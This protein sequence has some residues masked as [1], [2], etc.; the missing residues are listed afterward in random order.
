[1]GIFSI[2]SESVKDLPVIETMASRCLRRRLN[3]N[4]CTLCID[5]C[6][7]QALSI[8]ENGVQVVASDRCSSCGRCTAVCP[9]EVF[10]FPGIDLHRTLQERSNLENMTISCSRN[11]AV[12][13]NELCLPCIGALSMEALLHLGL[14]GSGDVHFDVT[15]CQKCDNYH[16]VEKV[17]ASMERLHTVLGHCLSANLTAIDDRAKLMEIQHRDRRSFLRNMGDNVVSFVKNHYGPSSWEKKSHQSKRRR[18]P[19]KTKLLHNIFTSDRQSCGE[20]LLAMCL[21]SIAVTDSCTLCPRCTGMCPTGALKVGRQEGAKKL[22][23]DAFR[24]NACGLCETFCKER[25]I[26]V[27]SAPLFDS[28]ENAVLRS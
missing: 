17:L 25:A 18:I 13:P 7:A 8:D 16:A 24:C 14:R 19:G 9:G 26:T 23:I 11:T 4:D 22:S 5:S 12:Y 21:P 15:G 28:T 27:T 2:I 1:M 3:S 10:S 6:C 20:E